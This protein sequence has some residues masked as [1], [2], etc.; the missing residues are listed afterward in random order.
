V[1]QTRPHSKCGRERY[2]KLSA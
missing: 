2:V 1:S